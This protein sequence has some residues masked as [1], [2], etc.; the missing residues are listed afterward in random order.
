MHPAEPLGGDHGAVVLEVVLLVVD[1]PAVS[2][3]KSRKRRVSCEMSIFPR[4][5]IGRFEA[6]AAPFQF[7]YSLSLALLLDGESEGI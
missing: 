3:C 5:S 1:D 7:P 4:Q 2:A 6:A